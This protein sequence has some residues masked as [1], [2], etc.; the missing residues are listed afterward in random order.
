MLFLIISALYLAHAYSLGMVIGLLLKS[1]F[2]R[3]SGKCQTLHIYML[4]MGQGLTV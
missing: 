1:S 4:T 3:P 2:V